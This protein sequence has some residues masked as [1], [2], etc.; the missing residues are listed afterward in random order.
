[1]MKNLLATGVVLQLTTDFIPTN[2][3]FFP[4]F[5][6]TSNIVSSFITLSATNALPD[7]RNFRQR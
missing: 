5:G 2:S 6:G 7:L 4:Y 3:E 1:M